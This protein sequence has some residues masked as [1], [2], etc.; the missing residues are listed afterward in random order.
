MSFYI[1]QHKNVY[2][3]GDLIKASIERMSFSFSFIWLSRSEF[4]LLD[5]IMIALVRLSRGVPLV[6]FQIASD[7]AR[8]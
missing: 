3:S 7:P 2:T 5:N 4:A 8:L 1:E 6:S